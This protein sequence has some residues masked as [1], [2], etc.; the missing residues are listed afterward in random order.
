[1]ETYN[2]VSDFWNKVFDDHTWMIAFG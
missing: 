1:M 2:G